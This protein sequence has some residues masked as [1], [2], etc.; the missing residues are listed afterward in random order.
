MCKPDDVRD[1][2]GPC[3]FCCMPDCPGISKCRVLDGDREAVIKF[4]EYAEKHNGI[5][6]A[7][8]IDLP[9]GE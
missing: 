4:N 2:G 7:A 6:I 1:D 8:P 5:K 9:D 3:D